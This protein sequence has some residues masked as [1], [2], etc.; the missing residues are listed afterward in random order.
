MC[1]CFEY[2]WFYYFWTYTLLVYVSYTINNNLGTIFLSNTKND[3][4]DTLSYIHCQKVSSYWTTSDICDIL[5]QLWHIYV[6][7]RFYEFFMAL[8]KKSNL[9]SIKLIFNISF[10]FCGMKREKARERERERVREEHKGEDF[11]I[12]KNGD[13]KNISV[14]ICAHMFQSKRRS[15]IK[16]KK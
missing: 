11:K 3:G 13:E 9:Y 14:R 8:H 7:N 16:K 5:W 10:I 2:Q 1:I 4:C 12:I 15:S 6:S